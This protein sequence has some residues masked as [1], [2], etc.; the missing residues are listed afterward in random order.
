[1]DLLGGVLLDI[2]GMELGLNTLGALDS[3]DDGRE[4]HEESIANR[5]DDRAMILSHCLLDEQV[6]PVKQTQHASF[7]SAHLATKAHHV[8]EHDRGQSAGLGVPGA[9]LWHSGD[10]RAGGGQLSNSVSSGLFLARASPKE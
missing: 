9:I 6:M 2:V 3:V 7:I 1:V 8:G 4:V 10:Y 5:F